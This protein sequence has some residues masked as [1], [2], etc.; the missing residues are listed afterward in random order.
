MNVPVEL[1][2]KIASLMRGDDGGQINALA[3][4]SF[5]PIERLALYT[6]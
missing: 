2:A 4:C 6:W 5:E 3:G 1:T